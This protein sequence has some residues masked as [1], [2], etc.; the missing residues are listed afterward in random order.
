[1]DQSIEEFLENEWFIV[2]HSGETPEIAY[3]SAIYF[4]TRAKEGPNL[5]LTEEQVAWLKDG[6][7]ERFREIVL[8]DLRHSNAGKTIYR[9][10]VRSI[11]NYQRFEKFCQRQN[12]CN[13]SIREEAA[14][15][16]CTFL[17]VEVERLRD[18]RPTIINCS[19]N[20]LQGFA[21]DLKVRIE[22]YLN[23]LHGHCC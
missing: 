18:G 13:N 9:G 19:C 3:N 4:L 23:K 17:S 7:V 20:Q 1:M 2:R 5:E 21:S 15:A 6:A 16:L 8:R 14:A 10:V 11:I 22:Q 12:I